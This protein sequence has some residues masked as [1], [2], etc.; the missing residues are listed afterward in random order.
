MIA[1]SL[2]VTSGYQSDPREDHCKAVNNN[3]KFLRK[4]K[5]VFL[6]Y[7]GSELKIEGYTVSGFQSDSVDSKSMLGYVLTLNGG[8]IS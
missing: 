2:R 1:P 3:L 7:S 6:V 4:T 8:V 5:D